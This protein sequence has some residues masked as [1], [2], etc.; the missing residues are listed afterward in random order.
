MAEL[1]LYQLLG[2][3]IKIAAWLLGFIMVAKAMTKLSI[4]GEILF[5][6]SFVGLVIFFV[7]LYGL[8]GVTIAFMVNYF[9]YLIFLYFSL[10][11]YLSAA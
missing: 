5:T 9:M 11:G 8:I 4:F 2:D 7:N 6:L 3:V 1:F 10:K